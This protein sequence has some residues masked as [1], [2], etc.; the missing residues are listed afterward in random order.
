M[1]RWLFACARHCM[2]VSMCAHVCMH[3]WMQ[4]LTKAIT[5]AL[6]NG[7]G[8]LICQLLVENKKDIDWTRTGKFT[9]M[10]RACA[11]YVAGMAIVQSKL[12]A[13]QSQF[14]TLFHVT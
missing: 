10:V 14:P 2:P 8:D 6:L 11:R 4:V 3:A 7:L 1:K 13:A 12:H 5:C 9:F